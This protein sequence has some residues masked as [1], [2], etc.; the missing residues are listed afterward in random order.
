MQNQPT[1]NEETTQTKEWSIFGFINAGLRRGFIKA[2]FALSVCLNVYLLYDS[3]R[4]SDI[5]RGVFI[6][7]IEKQNETNA[8]KDSLKTN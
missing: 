7:M 8:R 6:K 1:P 5:Y 2:V 3:K 4:T